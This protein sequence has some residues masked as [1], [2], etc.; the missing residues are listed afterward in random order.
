MLI[1]F[2]F[3]SFLNLY[4][5]VF[6]WF[7]VCTG[8]L[9]SFK[10]FK[11]F[12]NSNWLWVIIDLSGLKSRFISQSKSWLY[13]L[14]ICMTLG[15]QNIDSQFLHLW[16]GR[17]KQYLKFSGLNNLKVPGILYSNCFM[18]VCCWRKRLG[19][20]SEGEFLLHYWWFFILI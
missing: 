3:L 15:Y 10:Y 16:N 14:L 12:E 8:F 6:C 5:G 13:Y 20:C 2:H 18:N 19:G 4:F 11:D 1:F 7:L 17:M 9:F